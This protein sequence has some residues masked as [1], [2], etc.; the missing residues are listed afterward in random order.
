MTSAELLAELKAEY[1]KL[2]AQERHDMSLFFTEF[3]R[4]QIELEAIYRNRRKPL[5]H[6]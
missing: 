2:D 3:V 6:K 5:W 4:T 1:A